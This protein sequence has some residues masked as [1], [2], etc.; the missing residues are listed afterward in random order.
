M[1]PLTHITTI[2]GHTATVPRSRVGGRAI[3]RLTPI[4]RD[5]EGAIV[6]LGLFVDLNRLRG[7]YGALAA[8]T[9]SLHVGASEKGPPLLSC[10]AAWS[11][12]TSAEA[13]R[14]VAKASPAQAIGLAPPTPWLATILLPPAAADD[15]ERL[16]TLA[17]L[18]QCIA[19]TLIVLTPS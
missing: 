10:V 16:A 7:P 18:D 13:W 5:E 14:L 4:V 9:W 17:D 2:T 3:E 8:A 15:A 1:R 12:A 11:P 19:W 6:E